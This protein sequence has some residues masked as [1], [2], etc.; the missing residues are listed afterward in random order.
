M[1]ARLPN[2]ANFLPICF[3]KC[4]AEKMNCS[5]IMFTSNGVQSEGN[6]QTLCHTELC[7]TGRKGK[8]RR[9]KQPYRLYATRLD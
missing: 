5:L 6:T 2:I 9:E 1:S 8:N 4:F 7:E 3:Y